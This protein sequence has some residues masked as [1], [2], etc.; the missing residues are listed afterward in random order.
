MPK[1]TAVNRT[2]EPKYNGRFAGTAASKA[3][4]AVTYMIADMI[5][6]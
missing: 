3:R 1:D 5:S 4:G 2:R 6:R